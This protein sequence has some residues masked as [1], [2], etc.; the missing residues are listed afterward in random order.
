VGACYAALVHRIPACKDETELRWMQGQAQAL[1]LINKALS[2]PREILLDR[3][4]KDK[5]NATPRN[6]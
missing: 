5:E 2:S 4:E 3:E 1:L 6:F